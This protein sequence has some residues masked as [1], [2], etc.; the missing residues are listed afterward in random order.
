MSIHEQLEAIAQ[1]LLHE[2]EIDTP[3]VPVELMLHR[4]KDGMWE[5]VDINQLSGT[6][7]SVR[8]YYSPRISVARLLARHVVNCPWGQMRELGNLIPNENTLNAF[9][10][11]IIMPQEMVA[12]LRPATRNS[13]AMS[14]HFEVPE[15]EA[16]LR[17][18]E[19]ER[20]L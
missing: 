20:L 4:P 13:I 1:E 5:E 12:Q 10:R 3:P 18:Q 9:A 16:R 15:E 14:M 6:F 11:M 17:L 7:L 19:L 8:D 2:F